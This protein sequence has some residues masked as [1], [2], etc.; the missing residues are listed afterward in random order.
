MVPPLPADGLL[1]L[2]D[3]QVELPLAAFTGGRGDRLSSENFKPGA[4]MQRVCAWPTGGM[5]RPDMRTP[6]RARG[7]KLGSPGQLNAEFPCS[8]DVANPTAFATC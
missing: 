2:E 7:Q 8:R 5:T 3:E 6:G 4:D 1:S